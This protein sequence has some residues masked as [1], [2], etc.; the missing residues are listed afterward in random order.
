LRLVEA[1]S[2]APFGGFA[3]PDMI[4]FS[5]TRTFLVDA[6]DPD[7]VDLVARRVAHE[8][9]HQ[10]F[11]YR[12]VAAERAGALTLTESLTKYAELMVIE[13]LRGRDHVRQILGYELDR[14]LAGRGADGPK[15]RPLTTIGD[16]PYLYYGKGAIVMYAIRE[17]IGEE[18]MNAEI[19]RVIDTPAPTTAD[20]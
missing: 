7:R 13:R 18:A 1:P 10:W 19:R 20:L 16:Q 6:R 8:V 11:G 3:V 2:P 9:A 15:E 4:L 12:L 14:Y 17:L 5:E